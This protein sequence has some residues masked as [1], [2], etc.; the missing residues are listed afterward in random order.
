M[1]AFKTYSATVTP[2]ANDVLQCGPVSRR[3]NGSR[4]DD[5]DA[6]PEPKSERA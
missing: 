5:G 2:A 4:A 3:V 1:P 6:N